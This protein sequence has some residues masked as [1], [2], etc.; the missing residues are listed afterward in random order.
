MTI[1]RP[2]DFILYMNLFL[3]KKCII[4]NLSTNCTDYSIYYKQTHKH[5][6]L[7][8]KQYYIGVLSIPFRYQL[9][10]V[11]HTEFI[12]KTIKIVVGR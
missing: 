1:D 8:T 9:Y 11:S 5:Q 6:F 10:Y 12:A 7:H 4:C 3:K 2:K